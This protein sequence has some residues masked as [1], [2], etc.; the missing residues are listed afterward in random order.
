MRLKMLN[1]IISRPLPAEQLHILEEIEY[2]T[3]K[4]QTPLQRL[5]HRM[6]PLVAFGIMPIFALA[7]AGVQLHADQLQGMIAPV[8]VG[9][10]FGLLAG[11]VLGVVGITLILIR[12]KIASMPD[13][14][15]LWHLFGA[16]FLAA[17]GFTM[18]LFITDLAFSDTTLYFSGKSRNFVRFHY[19]QYHRIFSD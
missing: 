18:S 9:V 19:S 7:N 3:K 14:M 10:F 6:H 17:I 13:G 12:L 15:N 5:E 4:A 2:L 11:K 8:S 1:P 16:G